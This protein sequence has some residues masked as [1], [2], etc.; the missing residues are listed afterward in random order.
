MIIFSLKTVVASRYVCEGSERQ[1]RKFHK[2]DNGA[3]E[4]L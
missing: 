4:M 3:K 2:P 1:Y